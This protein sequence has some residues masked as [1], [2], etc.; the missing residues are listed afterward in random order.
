M[1]DIPTYYDLVYSDSS[2][3]FESETIKNLSPDQVEKG[4][5][6][7]YSILEKLENKEEID[8]G[9][10]SGLVT[11]GISALAGPAIMKAICTCLSIDPNGVLGKLLTSKLVLGS[12]G[13]TLGK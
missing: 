12:I 13:Y 3:I 1:K 5:D 2:K 4:E 11:G 8:E 9:F 6:F 7:Y 10:L